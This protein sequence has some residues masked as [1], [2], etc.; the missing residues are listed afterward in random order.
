MITMLTRSGK[1]MENSCEPE[2]DKTYKIACAPQEDSDQHAHFVE[3][4]YV[5]RQRTQSSFTNTAKT[6][7]D[8]AAQTHT[9]N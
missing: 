4:L 5:F 7:A 1:M 8:Q 9:L 2:T 6:Q 3:A